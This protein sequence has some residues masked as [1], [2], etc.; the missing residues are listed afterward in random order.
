MGAII[1][2]VRSYPGICIGWQKK[3]TKNASDVVCIPAVIQ[4]GHAHI[5]CK[6]RYLLS[7]EFYFDVENNKSQV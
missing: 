1:N 6:N 3:I 4:V 2:K 7:K 5:T